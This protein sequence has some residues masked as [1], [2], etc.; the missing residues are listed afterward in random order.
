LR[1][2]RAN[3]VPVPLGGRAFEIIEVL[4]HS[5]GDLVTKDDLM[6][7]VWPGAV[8]G[9]NT[10]Q[11]HM[12]AVRKAL[13]PDRD[14]LKTAFG[15]GYRLLGDWMT[16][17]GAARSEPVADAAAI[18][19]QP[20][21][22]NLPLATSK[23]IGRAGAVQ[24]VAD[25]LSAY[26][27]VTLTG[28]GGIGKTALSL[29]IAR[30]LSPGFEGDAWLVELASLS[31]PVLVPTAVASAL[32][33]R[34]GGDAIPAESVGRAVGG[35]RLLMVLDNCEHVIDAAARLAE[36]IIRMCPLASILATSREV[37]R[38]EGECVYRVP[39]LDVPKENQVESGDLLGHSAVQLFIARTRAQNS[40]FT[41]REGDLPA[42]AAICRRLEGIPLAI[43]FASARAAALGLAEVAA[44]LDDR[45][46]TLTDGRRTALPR[47]QT[48]RATLD[49]SY[50][51]LPEPEQRQ[52]RR[53]AVFPGGFTLEAATAVMQDVG[54]TA[55]S[56][57]GA[58]ASLVGKSL[59]TLDGSVAAERWRLLETVR[60]YALEKL[61]AN[62]E[63]DQIAKRHAKFFRD[64]L[65]TALPDVPAESIASGIAHLSREI[66]NVRA[67]LDWA[68][69]AT[70]DCAL[71]ADMTAAYVPVWTQLSL[72][73]ECRARVETALAACVNPA[74]LAPRTEMILRA[75]LGTS[76]SYTRGP[77]DAADLNWKRV[78]ELSEGL[79]DA[80]FQLRA[81]YGLWL[82]KILVCEYRAAL[83]LAQRFQRVAAV[84]AD[85]STAERMMAMVLHYLGDQGGACACAER[86]LDGPVPTNR[87]V[88]TTRYGLDQRVGALVQLARALW[89]QGFPDQ[90]MQAAQASV[91]EAAAVAHANSMCL[92]LA[93]GACIVAILA[94]ELDDAG[95]FATMLTEHA[96]KHDL[97]VWRT[98]GRALH[99]RLLLQSG[100]AAEGAVFLR[101]ALDDLR[102]TPFDIRFQ[103]Y[104]VWLVEVLASAG[105]FAVAL[106]AADEALDRAERTEERWYLP[107]LLRL[108]GELLL[109]SGKSGAAVEALELFAQSL[110][111]A[112]SQKALSW[113]LRTTMSLVRARRGAADDT[114]L[115][116][117]LEAVLAAFSEG[118]HTADLVAARGLLAEL[119]S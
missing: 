28:P 67:A 91:E 42:I 115:R 87:H 111:M 118:V 95:Q 15:R 8:V 38:I 5:A 68:F 14:L 62:G 27:T 26:R 103:L 30:S 40:E 18:P 50:G 82:Y 90:A 48:L 1:E 102:E 2:L 20:N 66:D 83:A 89:L 99:G 80:E 110:R 36:T 104:L 116:A 10:L 65:A 113:E 105:Q 7:Q 57:V 49:W 112:Q 117:E 29:E 43:E 101:S 114:A 63:T 54:N 51:L 109:Q 61:A 25:L 21:F 96:D 70:G 64:L 88:F 92:A 16:E 100:R 72:F 56:G 106:T 12:A 73:G 77:V 81:L 32:G 33:L 78:L 23:L 97:G 31:D 85:I 107:E 59:V 74:D 93:D 34:L 76:L 60:A 17:T 45:F 55:S 84:T 52:L 6:R 44:H 37:L 69:S 39:P 119:D 13:G 47:H 46:D 3:G 86:S 98:Y 58:V 75:A 35:R 9:N 79:G 108:R 4:V 41:P 24:H 22:T 53:L 71:G 11:V 94:G 19:D